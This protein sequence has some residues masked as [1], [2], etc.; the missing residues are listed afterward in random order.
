MAMNRRKALYVLGAGAGLPAIAR[1]YFGAADL[2]VTGA[3]MHCMDRDYVN[4]SA[5]AVRGE[6][7]LAVGTD[8]EI[9]NLKSARTIHIDARG[10]TL[11][12][13]HI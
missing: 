13:I 7:I 9:L 4:A 1:G 12:L 8:Q 10:M 11:S 5:M 6:R 2:I 3:N